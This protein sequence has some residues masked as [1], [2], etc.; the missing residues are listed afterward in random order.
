MSFEFTVRGHSVDPHNAIIKDAFDQTVL[1]LRKQFGTTG[2]V[3]GE[4]YSTDPAGTQ[5]F[6]SSQTIDRTVLTSDVAVA[7][8]AVAQATAEVTAAEAR[9]AAAEQ[10]LADAKKKVSA[11]ETPAEETPAE[12]LTETL[13]EE[14]IEE[15]SPPV[16]P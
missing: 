16:V 1:G 11:E 5:E 13:A 7:E 8:A 3:N 10:A 9:K 6:D 14:T 2:T 15:T 12:E 4:G